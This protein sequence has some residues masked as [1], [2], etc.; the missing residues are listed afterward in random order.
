MLTSIAR[1]PK[2]IRHIC[3]IQFFAWIGWF[4]CTPN[5][6]HQPYNSFNLEHHLYRRNLRKKLPAN[7]PPTNDPPRRKPPLGQSH[8]NSLVRPP[9]PIHHLPRLQ[10]HSP[11]RAHPTNHTPTTMASESFTVC[12]TDGLDDFDFAV[13]AG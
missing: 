3:N 13:R 7:S 12:G 6:M 1:L 10:S 9:R 5:T 4:L 8:E 11:S 2:R